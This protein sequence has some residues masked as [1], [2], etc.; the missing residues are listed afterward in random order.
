MKKKKQAVAREKPILEELLTEC[1]LVWPQAIS[2]YPDR[3]AAGV[4]D[5]AE[6]FH[7]LGLK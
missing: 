2:K 7:C 1:L 6:S 3:Q 4:R 5:V